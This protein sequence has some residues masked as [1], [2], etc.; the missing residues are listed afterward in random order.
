MISYLSRLIP[1]GAGTV[2][3]IFPDVPEAVTEVGTRARHWVLRSMLWRRRF[4]VVE[5]HQA[6]GA[7]RS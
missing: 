4:D 3:A 2:P 6:I 1:T 7:A 5:E